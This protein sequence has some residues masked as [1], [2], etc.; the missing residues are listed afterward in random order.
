MHVIETVLS[1]PSGV[2][3]ASD[4]IGACT[5]A[6]IT[7]S[8]TPV[9]FKS[10]NAEGDVSKLQAEDFIFAVKTSDDSP[11]FTNSITS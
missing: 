10:F 8:G 7:L 6:R 4:P 1:G 11:A 5:I 3:P 9:P 2:S